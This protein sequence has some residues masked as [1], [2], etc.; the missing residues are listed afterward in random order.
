MG[1]EVRKMVAHNGTQM[2][3][4]LARRKFAGEA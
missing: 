3:K 1:V 4:V 2:T